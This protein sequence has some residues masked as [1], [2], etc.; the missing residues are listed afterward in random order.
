VCLQIIK[1]RG[2][3]FWV[4]HFSRSQRLY[5]RLFSFAANSS[6]DP[7]LYN[8]CDFFWLV[9]LLDED[10]SSR[11]DASTSWPSSSDLRGGRRTYLSYHF[12]IGRPYALFK[13]VRYVLLRPLRPELDGQDVEASSREDTSSLSR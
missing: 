6:N 3:N 13:M 2:L 10:V 9:H 7:H 5:I 12:R 1:G 4:G 8:P 11:E